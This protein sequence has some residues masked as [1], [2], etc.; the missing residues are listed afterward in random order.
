[1]RRMRPQYLSGTS[2]HRF[3]RRTPW[4]KSNN[5]FVRLGCL[6]SKSIE[7]TNCTSWGGA[8]ELPEY[9]PRQELERRW[10]RVRRCMDC[11]SL[12]VLQSVD[13]YYLT[14]TVQSGVLWF[15]REG[16]PLLAVRKSFQRAQAESA[17]RNLAPLKSYSDL[18]RLIPNPGETI[19]FE[20]DVLPLATYQ[21][22]SK[23]FS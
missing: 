3:M 6:G 7:L 16:E 20:L 11:D 18:P 2:S 17:V 9:V 10:A 19:G 4:T 1:M 21:Q 12:V 5:S 8:M 14:G 22:V 23:H 13:L 15:P